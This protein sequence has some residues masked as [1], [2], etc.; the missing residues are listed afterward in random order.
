VWE[1]TAA[2]GAAFYVR[3]YIAN[4]RRITIPVPVGL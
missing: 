4:I 1:K 3:G 2:M